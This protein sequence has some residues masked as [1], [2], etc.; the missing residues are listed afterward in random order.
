MSTKNCPSCNC[1]NVM[2]PD[3]TEELEA[4]WRKDNERYLEDQAEIKQ[5]KEECAA[6][7]KK[8][9][10]LTAETERLRK[11][12]EELTAEAAKFKA[13]WMELL[14]KPSYYGKA[15][16]YR[17]DCW[18]L[19]KERDELRDDIH[20]RNALIRR[21]E[22]ELTLLRAVAE[23]AE[24]YV[25]SDELETVAREPKAVWNRVNSFEKMRQALAAWRAHREG[26]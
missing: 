18:K 24:S 23:A 1:E 11:E 20:K 9:A 4:R 13:M 21:Q 17:L 6:W 10:E 7:A 22:D 12:R 15:A 16:R 26:K 14:E 2:C 3:Y 19:R 25:K 5:L 8:E